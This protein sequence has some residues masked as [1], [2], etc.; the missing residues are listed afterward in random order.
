MRKIN[1]KDLAKHSGKILFEV[2]K[3][4]KMEKYFD[5]GP[6][7]DNDYEIV[8]RTIYLVQNKDNIF[9]RIFVDKRNPYINK[10]DISIENIEKSNVQFYTPNKKELSNIKKELK[11]YTGYLIES[12]YSYIEKIRSLN[13]YEKLF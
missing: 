3:E 8:T 9:T 2:S 11:T 13:E 5:N 1:T 10:Y 7:S 6:L 12:I 4:L